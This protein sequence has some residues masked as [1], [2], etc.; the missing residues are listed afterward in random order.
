MSPLEVLDEIQSVL[1]VQMGSRQDFPFNFSSL[2]DVEVIIEYGS[3][4]IVGVKA[5][6]YSNDRFVDSIL[7]IIDL[8]RVN[9]ECVK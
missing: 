6:L 1:R 4:S 5:C 2:Q 9:F 8:M 7:S 3:Y